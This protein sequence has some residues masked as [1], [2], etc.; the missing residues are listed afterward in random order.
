VPI[1]KPSNYVQD[2]KQDNETGDE[3]HELRDK[4]SEEREK[5]RG[6]ENCQL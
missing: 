4:R 6:V 2:T 5:K 1:D 3:N